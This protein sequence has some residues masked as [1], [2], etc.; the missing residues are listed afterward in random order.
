L[1]NTSRSLS[2]VLVCILVVSCANLLA[3]KPVEA[4]SIPKPSVPQFTVRYIDSSYDILPT[5]GIDQYTGEN[6]TVKNGEHI[7]NRTIEFTVKNQ[8]FT[9]Y[10]D[11]SGNYIGLYYNFRYKGHYGTEWSY[12]PFNPDWKSS[13]PYNGYSWGTGDLSPK[14]PASNSQY[15]I[16]A[17][18]LAVLHIPNGSEVE[19]QAQA[20]I[21]H[22]DSEHSGLLSGSFYYFRGEKSD[23]SN[24]HTLNL[25]DGSVSIAPTQP[26]NPT[27]TITHSPD[28]T[29]INEINPTITPTDTPHPTGNGPTDN[30]ITLPLTTL[31]LIILIVALVTSLALIVFYRKRQRG[32]P[33]E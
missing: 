31:V 13:I 17:L 25:A 30:S 8:P 10:T 9:T 5:Y 12:Y 33:N 16:I 7:D 1:V 14:L 22:I 15:T 23:W 28:Q 20:L 29:T 4:Q 6:I 24:T 3:V 21:G 19:L 18:A 32:K 11:S 27:P 26:P 2:M